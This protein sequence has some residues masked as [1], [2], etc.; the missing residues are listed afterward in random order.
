MRPLSDTIRADLA[1]PHPLAAERIG[2]EYGTLSEGG[3]GTQLIVLK[4]YRPVPDDRY[5]DD[6][7]CGARI[8]SQAIR[9]AMQHAL[10]SV[11]GA[12]HVHLHD[13]PG[14]PRFSQFDRKELPRL[15]PSF[16]ALRPSSAH[17][18]LLLSRDQWTAEVWLPGRN[19][20]IVADRIQV[21]GW[22]RE[23][24]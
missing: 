20:G 14:I 18:L 6:P 21:I 17:G 1:R 2:F 3:E 10:D 7:R 24:N 16:Q 19:E 12:F 11:A 15:I 9:G 4:D 22:P 5:L 13:W 23:A 8:D